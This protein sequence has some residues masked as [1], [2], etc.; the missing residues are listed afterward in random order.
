MRRI[1]VFLGAT[2]ALAGV[3][4]G[5]V[6]YWRRHPRVGTGF[7]NAIV[8]PRLLRRGLTGG[9][10]SEIGTIEH[11]G[12]KSGTRRLTPVHPEPMPGGFRIVVPLGPNSLWARNVIAA[13][14]CRLQLHETVYDL[15]E[16]AM[17][18]ASDVDGLPSPVRMM[19]GA[20][21]FEYL[22]LRAFNTRPG[23]LEPVQT[24]AQAP[25]Q[26]E[27]EQPSAEAAHGEPVAAAGGQ[28]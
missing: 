10:K 12:W 15:D 1:A 2:A 19:M 25:A 27:P 18:H 21:G 5:T 14:H 6:I 24:A 11:V 20:L 8:N 3:A 26:T 28:R 23:A 7:V 4:G 17:V 13:G 9:A 22:K 16:P